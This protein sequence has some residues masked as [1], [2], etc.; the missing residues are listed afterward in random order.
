MSI[1]QKDAIVDSLIKFFI[2]LDTKNRSFHKF[3]SHPITYHATE[4]TK[5]NDTTKAD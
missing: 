3:S 5:P 4:E 1:T 2:P